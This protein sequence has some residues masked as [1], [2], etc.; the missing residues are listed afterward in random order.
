M[1]MFCKRKAPYRKVPILETEDAY[2]DPK[3][4]RKTFWLCRFE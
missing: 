1:E 4:S 3:S 2:I